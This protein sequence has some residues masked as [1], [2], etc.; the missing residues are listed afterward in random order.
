MKTL[1]TKQAWREIA[2]AFAAA[3]NG[4]Q[5][6]LA[7]PKSCY[8]GTYHTGICIVT[9]RLSVRGRITFEQ[10]SAMD[11]QLRDLMKSPGRPNMGYFWSL[12]AEGA[13]ARCVAATLLAEG[14]TA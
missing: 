2:K 12:D 13:A 11:Q 3:A 7:G 8:G 14:A 1:T 6:A 5:N 9:S 4:G 10:E